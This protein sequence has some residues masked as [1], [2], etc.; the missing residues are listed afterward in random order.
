MKARPVPV[1]RLHVITDDAVLARSDFPDA[2]LRVLEA[3]PA[4][5]LHL[6]G[7]GTG[8]RTLF[9]L[10]NRLRPAAHETGAL[11]VVNDRVDVALAA[12]ADGVHLAE[13]SLP[14]AAARA[15]LP[16]PALV[17]ASVHDLGRIREATSEGA[18]YLI[19]G[20]IYA[21][22][23]HPE[24]PG[25]GPAWLG[26]VATATDLPLLA[27]GGV[28]CDR[29]APCLDAGAHGV[30]VLRGVWD[31]GD[32]GEAV[33]GYLERLAAVTAATRT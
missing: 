12:G 26:N 24:R 18:D 4:V 31:A 25:R 22:P 29:V 2:A 15:L 3:G 23:S 21:T 28:S 16:A 9:E 14:V 1:S 11:L 5:T 20:T 10:T 19:V 33:A 7:P 8:A 27:I 30:A 13:A 17:G 32:T 6:R